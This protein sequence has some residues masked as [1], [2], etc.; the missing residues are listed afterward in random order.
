MEVPGSTSQPHLH[1]GHDRTPCC[2]GECLQVGCRQVVQGIPNLVLLPE[3][4]SNCREVEL[5]Q[6]RSPAHDTTHKYGE[7]VHHRTLSHMLSSGVCFLY[8][9]CSVWLPV[10]SAASQ[11]LLQLRTQ[12]VG[13]PVQHNGLTSHMR[14][15]HTP[16]DYIHTYLC[17]TLKGWVVVAERAQWVGLPILRNTAQERAMLGPHAAF[18]LDNT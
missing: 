11:P 17:H 5:P 12:L 7:L 10:A 8:R 2:A 9:L 4:A 14:E 3:P 18:S 1:S 16:H 15:K 13:Q 6:N